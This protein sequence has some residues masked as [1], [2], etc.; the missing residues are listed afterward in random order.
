MHD[1]FFLLAP[2][3]LDQPLALGDEI[4]NT[5]ALLKMNRHPFPA[6]DEADDWVPGYRV[7]ALGEMNQGIL[8]P[9]EQNP[10]G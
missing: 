9:F 7:A 2:R 3:N 10:R 5:R 1:I 8:L 6:R 4:L